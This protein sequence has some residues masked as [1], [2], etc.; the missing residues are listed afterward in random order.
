LTHVGYGHRCRCDRTWVDSCRGFVLDCGAGGGHWRGDGEGDVNHLWV[1]RKGGSEPRRPPA[2]R[3][4]S[5]AAA[6]GDAWAR[7]PWPPCRATPSPGSGD[8]D[9]LTGRRGHNP[10]STSTNPPSGESRQRD[11]R[12]GNGSPGGGVC[13]WTKSSIS[14]PMRTRFRLALKR[15]TW[16]RLPELPASKMTAYLSIPGAAH[17]ASG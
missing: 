13:T 14:L 4:P 5:A 16:T 3:R 17:G 15:K 8:D 10:T 1:L 7:G 6:G 2:R 9:V 12:S 11:S